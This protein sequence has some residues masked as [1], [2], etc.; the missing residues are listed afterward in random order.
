MRHPVFKLCGLLFFVVSLSGCFDVSTII[1]VR[2]DGTGTV[3]ERMLMS[4]ASLGQMVELVE[5]DQKKRS[6]DMPDKSE[7]KKRAHEMGEGVRFLSIHPVA[8]K[9][10]KGYEALYAFNNID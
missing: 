8:T 5:K 7:L 9:S 1:T 3:A 2:P 10:H 6:G 4:N